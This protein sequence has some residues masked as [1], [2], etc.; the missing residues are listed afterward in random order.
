MKSLLLD[1]RCSTGTSHFGSGVAV[2]STPLVPG[3]DVDSDVL[4]PFRRGEEVGGQETD[5]FPCPDRLGSQDSKLRLTSSQEDPSKRSQTYP[6]TEE[7]L[8]PLQ[9]LTWDGGGVHRIYR[10]PFRDPSSDI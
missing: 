10:N 8:D 2:P 7:T 5:L 3:S 1:V 4:D 9:I 6:W